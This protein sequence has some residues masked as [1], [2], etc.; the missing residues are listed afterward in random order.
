MSND[1][2]TQTLPDSFEL[3]FANHCSKKES[4]LHFLKGQ[5]VPPSN[6]PILCYH[7]NKPDVGANCQA[8]V[9]DRLI[10]HYV[11]F[12]KGAGKVPIKLLPTFNRRCMQEL[13]MQKTRFYQL[14][15]GEMPLR[16]WEAERISAIFAEMGIN[17][18]DVFDEVVMRFDI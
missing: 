2:M 10:P 18:D 16:S 11:G 14:R 15:K 9:E 12:M 4:C 3:C 7:P 5:E 8:Y 6:M 1:S 17:P 13:G